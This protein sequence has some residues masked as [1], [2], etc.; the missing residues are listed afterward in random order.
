MDCGKMA[1]TSSGE[2]SIKVVTF[3]GEKKDWLM[4]EKFHTRAS[5]RGYKHILMDENI[6]IPKSDDT[7]LMPDKEK[8][9]KLN[10]K[11]YME[12]ILSMDTDQPGGSIAFNIVKGTKKGEYK[13]GNVRLAWINL[14]KKYALMMAPL[15][16]RMSELYMNAKLRKGADPDVYITY[17]ADSLRD[18]LKQMNWVVTDTQFMVGVEQFDA[19][20][21][22]PGK[23]V[24]EKGREGRS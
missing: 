9:K 22:Y 2:T 21:W 17:L 3:S 18:H 23:D 14:K 20:V 8:V 19:R 1:T 5:H 7:G 11:V 24:G 6:E 15:L 13:E 12:L 10:E 16:M 4:W